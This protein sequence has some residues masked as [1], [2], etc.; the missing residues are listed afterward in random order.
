VDNHALWIDTARPQNM[1]AGCDGGLYRTRDRGATWRFFPNI[2]VTQFYHVT[3]DNDMPFYN[4]YGGTQ[5]NATLGGPVQN[6][7]INGIRNSDWFVT[8]FGDGFKT[9]VDPTDAN[10]VYSQY[11]YGG[12]VRY[13]K[14]NGEMVSIQPQPEKGGE[15]LRWNWNAPIIVSPHSHTRLYFGSNIL[16]RSDDRGNS[17]QPVSGD[18]TRHLDRN[19]LKVMGKVWGPDAIAKNTHLF[20]WRDHRPGRIAHS[21]RPAG[22]RQR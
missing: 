3:A 7:S 12:L 9:V 17:W 15:A 1:L 2:P 21:R 16:F 5:D 22:G 14:H 11:Q 4:V 19:K 20:L 18:L 10:I 8:V 13:D 6:T